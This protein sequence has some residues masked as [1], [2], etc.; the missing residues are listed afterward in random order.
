SASNKKI[1]RRRR[2]PYLPVFAICAALVTTLAVLQLGSGHAAAGRLDGCLCA[3]C[4]A[5][6]VE[7]DGALD[8]ARLDDLDDLDQLTHQASLLQRQ[9]VDVGSAEPL[10]R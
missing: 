6:A 3:G 9:Q 7:L 2:S 1:S 4:R 5:N 8:L 10:Q